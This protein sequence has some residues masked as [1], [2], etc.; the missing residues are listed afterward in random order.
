MALIDT[1]IAF[2]IVGGFALFIWAKITKQKPGAVIDGLTSEPLY[3]EQIKPIRRNEQKW[4]TP[5]S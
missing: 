3:K 1:L 5:I 2:L 4:T